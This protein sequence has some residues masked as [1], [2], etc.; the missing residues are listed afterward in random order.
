MATKANL[1][2]WMNKETDVAAIVV[3]NQETRIPAER[4]EEFLDWWEINNAEPAMEL[5]ENINSAWQEYLEDNEE[6]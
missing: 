1:E 6:I 4:W 2:F 5:I 3:T